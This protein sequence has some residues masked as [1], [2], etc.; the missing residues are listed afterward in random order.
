MLTALKRWV[1]AP[2]RRAARA[3]HDKVVTMLGRDFVLAG[4][5]AYFAT[6]PNG[7]YH[8]PLFDIFATQV[9][10]DAICLDIG[11]N[12]GVTAMVLARLAPMGRVLAIEPDSESFDYLKQNIVTNRLG[13]V[14]V[15][16]HLLGTGESQ[17]VFIRNTQIPACSASAPAAIARGIT[18]SGLE[19]IIMPC[20]SLDEVVKAQGLDRLDFIKID[21]EGADLEILEGARETL[22]RFHPTV[23]VEFNA[24]CLMNFARINPPEALERIMGIF[25]H[26]QRIAISDEFKGVLAPIDDPYLFMYEHVMKHGCREDLL[27]TF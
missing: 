12:I 20:M 17:K 1:R 5:G 13:N 19:H 24:H 21:C 10:R 18:H 11:A 16:Q 9:R 22:S 3:A 14:V 2:T 23:V 26:V 15:L 27:C 8:D 6:L 25:P 7:F 4:R